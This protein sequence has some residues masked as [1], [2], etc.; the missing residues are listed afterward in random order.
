[1]NRPE[2]ASPLRRRGLFAL[3]GAGV[4]AS[5]GTPRIAL[6]TATPA[7]DQLAL[8]NLHTGERLVL[9]ARADGGLIDTE[10]A[11]LNHFLR[12]H[13][14]NQVTEIDPAL[15]AQ[16]VGLQR[17]LG[18]DTPID[19]ISAYRSPRTNAMLRRR[20]GRGVARHSK[21]IEGRAIDIRIPSVS[22]ASVRDAALELAAGG[23]GYYPRS[24]FIHLDTGRVR[25]W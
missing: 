17:L 4:L 7:P 16:L 9:P 6:A 24:K 11:T 8:R 18:K 25:R 22:L 10:H 5:I 21:H 23:V 1:M 20:R 13:Y 12:D 14:N 3:A 15:F 19:V 2:I